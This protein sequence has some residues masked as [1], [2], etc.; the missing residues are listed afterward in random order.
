[1]RA[2]R[3]IEFKAKRL[4]HVCMVNGE[5]DEDR[6]RRAVAH[7]IADKR[8]GYIPLLLQFKRL[9]RLHVEAR[10]AAVETTM[11]LPADL[12]SNVQTWLRDTYGKGINVRYAQ[13]PELIG[14]MRLRVGN[15]VYDGSVKY[16]LAALEKSF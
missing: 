7:I 2:N 12:R 11:P 15:D 3:Q 1:M 10:T 4:F 6:T 8:R 13:N 14:G 9:I 16:E 5:L